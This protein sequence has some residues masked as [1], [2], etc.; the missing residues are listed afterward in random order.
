M[1]VSWFRSRK[2]PRIDVLNG[3]DDRILVA[4]YLAFV[5]N[6]RHGACFLSAAKEMDHIYPSRDRPSW[7]EQ[8]YIWRLISLV[9]LENPTH[10]DLTR[11]DLFDKAL[12][13][14]NSR[15]LTGHGIGS[16]YLSSVTYARSGDPYGRKPDFAHNTY[17]QF[18][19]E[20]GLPLAFLFLSLCIW[21]IWRG[22]R[23][24]IVGLVAGS[25]RI[26]A[27]AGSEG[28]KQLA[29]LSGSFDRTDRLLLLGATLSLAAYLE[30]QLTANS[31]NV[32]VS[33]Q[34]FFWFLM[35]VVILLPDG[36]GTGPKGGDVNLGVR[37]S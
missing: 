23:D 5:W 17:L 35:A 12:R 33:N 21:A 13:M 37:I 16:F 28:P 26:T 25:E 8:P 9:R 1:E 2:R 32:Y 15:P 18:A 11:V 19:A 7:L 6:R 31:L 24:S 27:L 10:K 22:L 3:G 4:S 14:I 29:R 20:L 34:Y 36:G 30:T